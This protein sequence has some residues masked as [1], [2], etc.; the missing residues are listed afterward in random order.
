MATRFIRVTTDLPITAEAAC[1]LA[2]RWETFSFVTWPV[3]RI[4]APAEQIAAAERDG[5]KP[6]LHLKARL[7]LFQVIPTWNHELTLI[8]AEPR[9]L[10]TNE[11]SGP[12]KTWNHRLTFEPAGERACL[13]TDEIEIDDN[14][15]GRLSAPVINLFFRYR[16]WRWR[17][18]PEIRVRRS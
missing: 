3:L 13:Y 1:D 7:W 15:F 14:L 18:H 8:S 11:H 4:S 9:E 12:L 2:S 6:G 16:Q 5:L 17:H 10:Y